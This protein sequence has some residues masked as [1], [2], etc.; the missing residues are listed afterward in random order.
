[1]MKPITEKQMDTIQELARETKTDVS[2]MEDM[3]SWEASELI[4][5]LI[6]KRRTY[7]QAQPRKKTSRDYSSEAL[8]GLA[9]KILA[10]KYNGKGFVERP[11]EFTQNAVELYNLFCAARAA[12]LG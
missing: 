2:S 1:M 6:K 3:S 12:C 11:E 9:V 5:E 4:T 7:E 10:Q 8:A